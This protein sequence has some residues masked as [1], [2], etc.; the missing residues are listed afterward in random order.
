MDYVPVKI[1]KTPGFEDCID[2]TDNLFIYFHN[3]P[4]KVRFKYDRAPGPTFVIT[5]LEDLEL[6]QKPLIC[7]SRKKLRCSFVDSLDYSKREILDQLFDVVTDE[8]NKIA[9]NKIFYFLTLMPTVP[10]IDPSFIPRRG[11]IARYAETEF[12]EGIMP[13]N[14]GSNNLKV[15]PPNFIPKIIDPIE[16]IMRRM[17]YDI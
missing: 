12:S 15:S 13:L 9:T 7:A 16:V 4:D 10:I 1:I 14:M 11:I 8:L 6:I 3:N 2:F 17:G 5:I